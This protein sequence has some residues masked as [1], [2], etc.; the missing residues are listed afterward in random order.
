M[1][2]ALLVRR[3]EHSTHQ[4]RTFA[5]CRASTAATT[6]ATTAA[7]GQPFAVVSVPS[8]QL[9]A[10]VVRGTGSEELSD[11]VGWDPSSAAPG[12]AGT[13][14][15]AA[16][17]VTWFSDIDQ[18]APGQV[19][20]VRTVCATF[21]Y[22]V[23]GHQI[24]TEGAPV[25]NATGGA[26]DLVLV[27][28]WPTNALFFTSQRY[29]VDARL[30][31]VTGRTGPLPTGPPPSPVPSVTLPAPLASENL[32]ATGNDAPLGELTLTGQ[33]ALTW[34]QS[35]APLQVE[36]AGLSELFG[37]LR[38]AAQR[39]LSWIAPLWSPSG[40]NP[41]VALLPLFSAA[42]THYWSTVKVTIDAVGDQVQS[43]TLRTRLALSGGLAP[44]LYSLDVTETAEGGRL[45]VTSWSMLPY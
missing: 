13:A 12:E 23:T 35:P 37:V 41:Q 21:T 31:E 19:V 34:Q 38:S 15:L 1:A 45:L 44:G 11:A 5:T 39:Q 20:D 17:D 42:I 7:V 8:L 24:V 16:H 9:L 14:V 25:A 40:P 4:P 30:T 2:G 27:T 22:R 6:A 36:A 18:L 33:P 43:V 10:P 26:S 3:F 29:L 28:C 32:T